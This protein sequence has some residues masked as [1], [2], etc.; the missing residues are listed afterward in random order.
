MCTIVNA[1][2]KWMFTIVNAVRERMSDAIAA[3][4]ISELLV[5][6]IVNAWTKRMH[7]SAIS[8]GFSAFTLA[9]RFLYSLRASAN[10]SLTKACL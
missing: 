7:Y 5:C 10:L 6:T 2:R 9:T 1:G 8:S 3:V 4:T